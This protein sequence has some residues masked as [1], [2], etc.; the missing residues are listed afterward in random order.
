MKPYITNGGQLYLR[1]MG[2]ICL[3]LF[4]V[5]LTYAQITLTTNSYRTQLPQDGVGDWSDAGIWEFFDGVAWVAAAT[6]PNRNHDVFILKGN[7]VRLSQNQEVGNI[8]LFGAVDAGKKLNLQTFDLDVYGAL[9]SF[10]LDVGG[11]YVLYGSAWLGDDW[12]Y[13]ETGRIVFK[14][15]S[16]TVVD[17][18]SWSGQNLASRFSVVFNPDPGEV[19]VVNAGFK[20]SS[21]LIQSGT[22]RQTVNTDGAPATSTFSF[23]TTE[24]FG[25]EDFGELRIASGATLISEASKEFNQLIRR[26]ENRPASS[27]ILE[28]GAKL[29]LFGQE[30]EIDAVNV[31]LDGDVF[32]ASEKSFQE[33]LQASMAVSQ[34][35]FVYQNLYMEGAATKNLPDQLSVQGDLIFVSGGVADGSATNLQ[36]TGSNDQELDVSGLVLSGLLIDKE[37]G[38]VTI[39]DDLTVTENYSQVGGDVDFQQHQLTLDFDASGTYTYSGGNWYNLGELRYENLPLALDAGNARFPFFDQ[40]LDAPRHLFLEGN[41]STVGQ[42]LVLG[43]VEAPGVTY[44]P[45]FLDEGVAVV[46]HLNSFFEISTTGSDLGQLIAWIGAE[47]LAVQDINHLRVVGDGLPAIGLHVPAEEM[48]GWLWAKRAFDFQEAQ[49]S[50]LTIGSTSSLSV[51]PLDW[52]GLQANWIGDRVVLSWEGNSGEPVDYIITRSDREAKE[53]FPIDNIQ[54]HQDNQLIRYEDSSYPLDE[55][56]WFYQIVG[57]EM[58]GLLSYSPVIRVTNPLFRYQSPKIHPNPYTSGPLNLV[59][60]SMSPDGIAVCKVWNMEGVNFL[61]L[62]FKADFHSGMLEGK[63]VSLPAG[64]YLI[65]LVGVREVHTL[66]WQKHNQ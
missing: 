36:L 34:Q 58:D 13:P 52:N 28:E 24:L 38:L 30:P 47:D 65:Q 57:K 22:V 8:Y 37:G 1:A 6:P 33:F 51:L 32:Y 11:E 25:T 50:M 20:A 42:S 49:S 29:V 5:F 46:Y 60:G 23:T 61:T 27:F 59:L 43:Y 55:P 45:G 2:T 26:S 21:F 19:L 18:N 14:G 41:F 7:E 3:L 53:F 17:R 56:F 16:R 35:D 10:D 39:N 44:D 9:H 31:V 48:D 64:T 40:F 4:C 15:T 12:I 66:K 54:T 62:Y 63:L